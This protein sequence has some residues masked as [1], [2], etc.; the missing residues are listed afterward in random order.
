MYILNIECN[1]NLDSWLK[2]FAHKL[3]PSC[4]NRITLLRL[5]CEGLSMQCIRSN[6]SVSKDKASA[7]DMESYGISLAFCWICVYVSFKWLGMT[8]TC[9]KLWVGVGEGSVCVWG[10]V[11]C[12]E[13]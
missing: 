13:M 3:N 2:E 12:R 7:D 11:G 10:W 6:Y 5:I 4:S 1:P 8:K 9:T